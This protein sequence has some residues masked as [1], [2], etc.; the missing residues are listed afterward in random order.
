MTRY[1]GPL[2]AIDYYAFV[3]TRKVDR[4]TVYDYIRFLYIDTVCATHA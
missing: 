2:L 4:N 1:A 3:S